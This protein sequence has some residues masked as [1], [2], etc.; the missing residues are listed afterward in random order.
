MLFC[1]VFISC[2]ASLH[3]FPNFDR[4][5]SISLHFWSILTCSSCCPSSKPPHSLAVALYISTTC[6]CSSWS[7]TVLGRRC[8]SGKLES[9]TLLSAMKLIIWFLNCWRLVLSAMSS[10]WI[11]ISGSSSCKGSASLSD[12][13]YAHPLNTCLD[14]IN[15]DPQVI[16]KQGFIDHQVPSVKRRALTHSRESTP[17]RNSSK[18][19]RMACMLN[20]WAK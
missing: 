10:Q 17:A 2:N 14:V 6:K 9:S 15:A 16:C 19:S 18:R 1:W 5:N 8:E 7:R 11:A 3:A 4:S 12:F 13:C 20:L